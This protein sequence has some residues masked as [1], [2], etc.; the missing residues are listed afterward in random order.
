MWIALPF[1]FILLPIFFVGK[2]W[3]KTNY[4]LDFTPIRA[5]LL[6]YFL[7]TCFGVFGTYFQA[8]NFSFGLQSQ[9]SE[10]TISSV[11]YEYL[12]SFYLILLIFFLGRSIF[13]RFEKNFSNAYLKS[14]TQPILTFLLICSALC[15][16]CFELARVPSIPLFTFFT[17][18]AD[19]A[20]I[21]RGKVIDYQIEQ[22]IILLGYL[23]NHFPS[24]LFCWIV[25]RYGITHIGSIFYGILF[26][27]F[28]SLFL[29][30]GFF[31]MPFVVIAVGTWLL[32]KK[33]SKSLIVLLPFIVILS[34]FSVD[35]SL[36]DVLVAFVRRLFIVQAEGMFLIREYY[37]NI[38]QGAL[39]YGFPLSRYMGFE[40]FDPSV[41]IIAKLFGEVEGWVNM[42]SYAVGQGF[43]MFGHS[44]VI[45][46]PVVTA[47]NLY[48]IYRIGLFFERF[49][50]NGFGLTAA[51][52]Y[53]V[54]LPL[55]TNFSLLL[56][57]KSVVGMAVILVFVSLV[58][59]LVTRRKHYHSGLV[60]NS[61]KPQLK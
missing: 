6:C 32:N 17:E 2:S 60:F 3:E 40:S 7:P 56:Y 4:R 35:S 46:L 42:N 21:S 28:Y 24:I 54:L 1:L 44:I 15:M 33:N 31:I 11:F 9:L 53:A 58:K 39:L 10:R 26:F 55:N 57:F 13:R 37:P 12:I 30:K 47:I 25:L 20:S 45:V 14:P 23:I 51:L 41:E 38:D 49:L 19:S 8:V 5:L 16:F 27:L 18:G 29:A 48:L 59:I 34:F 52:Y 61:F 36:L 22:G 50:K 43:V